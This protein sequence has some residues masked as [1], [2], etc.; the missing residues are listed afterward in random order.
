MQ[1]LTRSI[2]LALGAAAT[3]PLA[4]A[5]KYAAFVFDRSGSMTTIR[6]GSATS[7][8]DYSA[9][10]AQFDIA[11]YFLLN[12]GA[13]V[14]IYSF[15]GS[16]TAGIVHHGNYTDAATAQAAAR[17]VG[18]GGVLPTV[19][20]NTPLSDAI[21]QSVTGLVALNPVAAASSRSLYLY[22]DGDQV[23]STLAFGCAAGKPAASTGERCAEQFGLGP[24]FEAGSWQEAVCAI[25]HGQITTNFYYFGD[26][27]D[28]ITPLVFFGALSNMTGGTLTSVPDSSTLSPDNPWRT[29]G[30]GCA[31]FHGTVLSMTHDGL[32][33]LGNVVDI[34][35]RTSNPLPYVLGVGLSKTS[36]GGS[37]LPLSLA[38]Q[39]AQGCWLLSSW[40]ANEGF[41]VWDGTR[42][43]P[44]P[45]SQS[46]VG[47]KLYY[48][49]AQ[50]H[51]NNNALGLAT[52]NLLEMKIS[53]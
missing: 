18:A 48:Q 23:P 20:G 16:T 12:P 8:A 21:C 41:F 17:E 38:P 30:T 14:Q 10:T 46:L 34:R 39:G 35:C 37:P 50:L 43:F 3:A 31:D 52:S 32:P 11:W 44:I 13:T 26:F 2:L 40:D 4:E 29:S 15:Q 1:N 6:S 9:T 24:A 36:I 45:N 28:A 27:T 42:T 7:R 47:L 22:S 25:V 33:Q 49:G 51:P 19:T 5:Q 53:Q